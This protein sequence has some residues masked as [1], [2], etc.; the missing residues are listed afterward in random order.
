MR[1]KKDL[2]SDYN[3]LVNNSQKGI[4]RGFAFEK[5][6]NELL[7]LE[8][9]NP[10]FSYKPTGEQIDGM[11][12]FENRYFHVECK[13]EAKPLPV[14]AIYSLRGKM[15]GKLVGSLGVFVSMSHF[16]PDVSE[17]LERG[18]DIN[19]LLFTKGD[20]DSC[21]SDKYTF[22]EILKIKMRYAAL[23]GSVLH[24]H[25]THLNLLK[26]NKVK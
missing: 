2:I 13:W 22:V 21:F 23:Y 11:F 15:E 14:S 25:S 19:I 8:E 20:V 6:F 24:E 4:K 3:D 18:K 5:L 17:A 1:L 12:E 26:Q 9:L 7:D 10:S 16:S